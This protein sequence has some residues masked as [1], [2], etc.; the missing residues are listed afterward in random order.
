MTSR[1]FVFGFVLGSLGLAAG[2]GNASKPFTIA[3]EEPESSTPETSTKEAIEPQDSQT[4]SAGDEVITPTGP[5]AGAEEYVAEPA[6]PSPAAP[7][8]NV[9]PVG[10]GVV[11]PGTGEEEGTPDMGEP[12]AVLPPPVNCD[13][14]AFAFVSKRSSRQN[15]FVQKEGR[16]QALT[17]NDHDFRYY[18][19]LTVKPG[20]R[21][22]T[23]GETFLIH[24]LLPIPLANIMMGDLDGTS[25]SALDTEGVLPHGFAWN[26]DGTKAAYFSHRIERRKTLTD[27]HVIDAATGSVLRSIPVDQLGMRTFGR[28][29]W[30]GDSLI[31]DTKFSSL[32]DG[33][34]ELHI[35]GASS[36]QPDVVYVKDS[37]IVFNRNLGAEP[38][39]NR[40]GDTLAYVEHLGGMSRIVTCRLTGERIPAY[41]V[42]AFMCRDAKTVTFVGNES[43]PSWSPDGRWIYFSSERAG[44]KDIYRVRADG[45]MEERLT[46]DPA[47]ES[48]PAP[49]APHSGCE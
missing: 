9:E 27:I 19:E 8:P 40:A 20:S 28:I 38:A 30:Q 39:V 33:A 46:D 42:H 36:G 18:R 31:Y 24:P 34:L 13:E 47:S 21:T 44:N 45:S 4:H 1:I 16:A 26:A 17:A 12:P 49:F 32:G 29:S 6:V 43:S 22:L 14:P 37:G 7:E 2:C 23:Y 11:D 10:G 35:V 15:V 3:Y 5:V 41:A 48:S 25:F